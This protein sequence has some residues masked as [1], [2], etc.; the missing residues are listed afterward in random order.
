MNP[1][2]SNLE[3]CTNA[4]N[5]AHGIAYGFHKAVLKVK[6]M[7]P[8]RKLYAEGMKQKDIAKIYKV[9]SGRISE[10]VNGAEVK[11]SF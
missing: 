9:S 10:I 7:E 2:A 11:Y 8:I 5:R 3:W 6:D 1:K 4:Q